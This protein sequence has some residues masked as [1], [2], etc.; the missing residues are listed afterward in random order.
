MSLRELNPA[1]FRTATVFSPAPGRDFSPSPSSYLRR[2]VSGL[3]LRGSGLGGLRGARL[4]R[5][6]VLTLQ[7]AALGADIKLPADQLG[8]QTH[9]L[10]V[11]AYGQGQLVVVNYD[12]R[13]QI[14]LVE[15]DLADL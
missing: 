1:S 9:I 3:D 13:F 14:L 4:S 15:F 11:L 8:G 7:K 2:S 5:R 6:F 10:A 12:L